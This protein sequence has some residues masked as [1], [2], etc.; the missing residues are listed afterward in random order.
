VQTYDENSNLTQLT[1]TS[2]DGQTFQFAAA[3]IQSFTVNPTTGLSTFSLIGSG[4]AVL[5]NVIPNPGRN[6]SGLN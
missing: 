5:G 3:A 6:E 1:Q 4:S 2:T